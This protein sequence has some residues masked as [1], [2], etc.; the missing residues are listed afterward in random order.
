MFWTNIKRVIKA[1]FINFWRNG[2]VSLSSIFVMVITLLVL[3]SIIFT[4]VMLNS[5][6]L[7]IKDKVDVNVYFVTNA[8]ETDIV[9]IKNSLQTLPQ[10][11]TVTYITRDQ[12]LA[13]FKARHQNDQ[14]TLQALDELQQNPLGAMLNI[15]AKDPSQYADI[16][17]FL[18]SKSVSQTDGLPI[19]DKVNFNSNKVAIDRLS[20][21]I[22]LGHKIGFAVMIALIII[23]LMIT[24]NTIR[25]A[26]YISRD[27]ISIMQLVGASSK[28]VRGP[29]VIV[30]IMYGIVSAIITALLFLPITYYLAK[31]TSNQII[32][33]YWYYVRNA[34]QIFL[35]LLISGV[36]I[37]AASSYLAV[38]RYLK[39]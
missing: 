32:N 35:L 26:I 23:S 22:D 14:Y 5:V 12:V 19:I 31:Y 10:I 6:L 16:V 9:A 25:L 2:F 1:G 29:F 13:D 34:G 17:S 36:L 11:Q 21:I 7:Q 37:G 8:N 4:S 18:Q 15:K 3:G 20:H 39:V 33:I 30:G 24:L 38:R 27:E 28:F